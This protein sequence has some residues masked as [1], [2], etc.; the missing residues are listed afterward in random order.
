M[1]NGGR[2]TFSVYD[3]WKNVPIYEASNTVRSRSLW[4]RPTLTIQRYI[5]LDLAC[6]EYHS[7]LAVWMKMCEILML[8]YW[9]QE[10]PI[11]ETDVE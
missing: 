2:S 8:W 3:R 4:K 6:L 9:L 7:V 1:I 5:F 11:E 10:S